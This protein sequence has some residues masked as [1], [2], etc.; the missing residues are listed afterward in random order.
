MQ[1]SNMTSKG[2]VTI[3]AELRR[4]LGLKPGDKVRFVKRG[5]KISIEAV[6]EPPIDSVFGLLKAPRGRGIADVD[7]ALAKLVDDGTKVNS[8]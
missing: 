7:A 2:Q 5:S 1:T 3:P 8:K 6:V 4:D